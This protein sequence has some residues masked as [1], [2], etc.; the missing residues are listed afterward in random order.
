MEKYTEQEQVRRNKLNFYIEN[1]IAP[2][3]K[4]YDLGKLVLSQEIV[5][6]YSSFSREELEEKNISINVTGRLMTVRGPFLVLKD[7]KGLIQ[8]YF[9]K[10]SDENLAKIVA[11]FDIG[12]ILWVSGTIMKTHTDALTLKCNKIE[13]LTKALKPLPEKYHGLVDTEERYRRRWVDL[14]TNDESKNKFILRTKIVK[15]IKEYFDNLDYLE[16]ETP[17]LQDYVSG[18]CG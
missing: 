17:F 11:T 7:S 14:I 5:D 18:A 8:V 13:L 9:N 6:K 16:V 4:A 15:W 3:K 2:F 12:D 10:K 1:N